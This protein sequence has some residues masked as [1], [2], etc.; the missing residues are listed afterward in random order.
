[1]PVA[2]FVRLTE[3]SAFM[4]FLVSV[5]NYRLAV[6]KNMNKNPLLLSLHF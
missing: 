1:M 2:I 6:T 4:I 3:G 5:T